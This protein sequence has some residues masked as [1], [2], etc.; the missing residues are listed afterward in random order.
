MYN[1]HPYFSLKDLG[2]KSVHYTWQNPGMVNYKKHR[3][4]ENL[5]ADVPPFCGQH[6]MLGVLY[7]PH[8]LTIA[9][10]ASSMT[11]YL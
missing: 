8:L 2:K 4:L 1:V 11:I 3:L 6:F 9:P 7:Q 10:L 5:E